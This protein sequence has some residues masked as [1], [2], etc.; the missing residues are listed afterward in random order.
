MVRKSSVLIPIIIAAVAIGVIGLAA[1]PPEVRQSSSQF[2]KGTVRINNDV[3]TVEIAHTDAEKQRWLTFRQ[4]KLPYDS[5]MLIKY[6]K[7]DLY[8]VWMLNVQYNL[9]LVWFNEN[10]TA[11]YMIKNAPPCQNLVESVS[12]TYKT[13]AP[14]VNVVAST[15]GFIDRHSIVLGSKMT[16]ISD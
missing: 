8:Q 15:A 12:C 4:D 1:A 6:D 10:G 13:T 5:A 3:I 2:P 14:A 11:V 16:I 7:P 9:D